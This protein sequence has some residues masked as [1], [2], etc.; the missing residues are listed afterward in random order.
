MAASGSYRSALAHRGLRRVIAAYA[1]GSASVGIL[2]VVVAVDIFSRTDSSFWASVAVSMRVL[3]FVLFSSFSGV[4]G[5]RFNPYRVLRAAIAGPMVASLLVAFWAGSGPLVGITIVGFAGHVAWTAAYSTTAT[6]VPRVVESQDLAPAVSLLTSVESLAF[7]VGPGLGGAVLTLAGPR[8]AAVVGALLGA[9]ACLITVHASRDA[10]APAGHGPPARVGFWTAYTVGVR[11]VVS[12]NAILVPLL[13]LLIAEV[14]YGACQVLL[15]LAASQLLGMSQGGF[16]GLSAALGVG[17][18][19][20]LFV[21]NRI[22]RS[23]Q[24]V[25]AIAVSVFACGVPMALVAVLSSP[26]AVVP[27]LAISGAGLLTTEVLVLTTLQRNVPRDRV[28]RAFG[29]LDALLVGGVFI[30]SLLAAPLSEVLGL[31]LALLVVGAALPALA[32]LALPALRSQGAVASVDVSALHHEIALLAGLPVLRVASRVSVEVIAAGAT[33]EVV[34]AG[35]VVIEQGAVPDDF[36]AIVSGTFAVLID[37][38]AGMSAVGRTLGAG[39][40]FGELGLLHEV[41]RMATVIASTDGELLRVPGESLITA[42]GPGRVSG[43]GSLVAS[44][45]DLWAAG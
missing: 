4:L 15:L 34:S 45:R 8:E 35:T 23:S 16:G 29:V 25:L 10:S 44:V 19:L 6:L 9:V 17:A 38:G 21:V 1:L 28:A 33:H 31:K 36:F 43:G 30:G 3:P 26:V 11:A 40:G 27:L 2:G 5:D 41:P 20:G 7:V 12:S 37:D 13:F 18:F 14:V 42:V 39:D 32:L 22:A 24:L